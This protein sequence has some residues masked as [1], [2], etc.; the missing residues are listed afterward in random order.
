MEHRSRGAEPRPG[1]TSPFL[2]TRQTAHYLQVSVRFLERLRR[3]GG[4]PRFR[5]HGRFVFY[6][7]DDVDAWSLA[8]AGEGAGR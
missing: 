4:G 8:S 2:N 5:R 3:R 1:R 7:R 6:H